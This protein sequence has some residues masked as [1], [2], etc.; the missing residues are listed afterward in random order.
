MTGR[1]DDY[2]DAFTE[3]CRFEKAADGGKDC[4]V[5]IRVVSMMQRH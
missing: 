3:D 5:S 2:G 4:V 1:D